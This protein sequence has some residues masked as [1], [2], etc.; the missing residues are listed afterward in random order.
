MPAE[1]VDLPVYHEELARALGFT[2]ADLVENRAGRLTGYQRA[3]QFRLISRAIAI[4]LVCLL[5][6]AGSVVLAFA[7]GIS[8]GLGG[9]ILLL[10]AIFAFVVGLMAWTS[11][12][13]WR[14][15]NSGL[16]SSIEGFVQPAEKET[17]IS[18]SYGPGMGILSF[19]WIVDDQRFAAPGKAYGVLTPA[20]HRLYFMPLTRRVV[21]AEPLS[22][23]Q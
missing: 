2:S 11:F 18:T 10:A 14:D 4:S 5:L 21:A 3:F 23:G 7:I 12:P 9:R 16:V 17:H 1:Y 13:L 15:L 8:F 20:R 19:Y 6:A 22:G